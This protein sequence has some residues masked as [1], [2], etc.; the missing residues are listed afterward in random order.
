MTL[1]RSGCSTFAARRQSSLHVLL[2]SRATEEH[3][4]AMRTPKARYT[5]EEVLAIPW[6]GNRREVLGGELFVT[7]APVLMH[8]RTVSLLG[9]MLAHFSAAIG[10]EMFNAPGDI[11]LTPETL[12][13]PDVFVAP[14]DPATPL[15]E[16]SQIEHLL[17][18]VEVVS[19]RTAKRDRTIKRDYYQSRRIP[20]YWIVDTVA[21]QV[22]RWRP[23]S[24]EAEVLRDLII[25]HPAAD[26]APL[27]IDLVAFFRTVWAE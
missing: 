4:L 18:V 13:Q 21:R 17:L 15:R 22:E 27:T 11:V 2:Y 24:T 10:G 12:V 1:A 14:L 16:W 25:W 9:Q 3:V 8:Q 7:P 6:D 19:P 26:H 5:V 23:D 20:E